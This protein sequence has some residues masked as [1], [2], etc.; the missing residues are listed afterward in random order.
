MR[1]LIGTAMVASPAL[2]LTGC[3]YVAVSSTPDQVEVIAKATAGVHSID[4]VI[5]EGKRVRDATLME[6]SCVNAKEAKAALKKAKEEAEK[7]GET[8]QPLALI[9]RVLERG[10]AASDLGEKL[11]GWLPEHSYTWSAKC[12]P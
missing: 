3:S 12:A 8:I 9:D 5:D 11:K 2:A 4:H 1:R 6:L 7:R 10:T